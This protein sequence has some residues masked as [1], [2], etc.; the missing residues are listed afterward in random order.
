MN[1]WLIINSNEL[2]IVLS[3]KLIQNNYETKTKLSC[4]SYTKVHISCTR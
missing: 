4:N 2:R 3:Y 1:P